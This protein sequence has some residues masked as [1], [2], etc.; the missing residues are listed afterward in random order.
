MNDGA[1][2]IGFTIGSLFDPF[3]V[4]VCLVAGF[5]VKGYLP[6]LVTAVIVVIL[7]NVILFSSYGPLPPVFFVAK[8]I[9]AAIW[10]TIFW[11][12]GGV[13]RKRRLKQ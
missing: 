6:A 11:S 13:W 2:L 9:A 12:I 4:L 8:P 10:V 3:L 7:L 1:I 5:A